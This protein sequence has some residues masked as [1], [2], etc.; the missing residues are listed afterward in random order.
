MGESLSKEI[1]FSSEMMNSKMQDTQSAGP[2]GLLREYIAMAMLCLEH[3]S[4]FVES[5]LYPLRILYPEVHMG[6]GLTA[7]IFSTRS[8]GDIPQQMALGPHWVGYE[9]ERM[10]K[11]N[12]QRILDE[13]CVR[14]KTK[15]VQLN[16]RMRCAALFQVANPCPP[17]LWLMLAEQML[18]VWDRG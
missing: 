2:T 18:W 17:H 13:E 16:A 4:C 15:T 11:T 9:T 8:H 5:Q 1:I 7:F 6:R 12:K 3:H 10:R 14:H